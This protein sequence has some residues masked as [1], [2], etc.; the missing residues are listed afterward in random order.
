MAGIA[1]AALTLNSPL[2]A[3]QVRVFRGDREIGVQ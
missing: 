3:A 2:R 1:F